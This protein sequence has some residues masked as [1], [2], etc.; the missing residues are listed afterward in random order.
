MLNN[1]L[2]I[3]VVIALLVMLFC[4]KMSQQRKVVV[5]EPSRE[6][7]EAELDTTK[8]GCLDKYTI[9][10]DRYLASNQGKDTSNCHCVQQ[11]CSCDKCVGDM[12]QWAV[13][14]EPGA[15]NTTQ[16]LSWQYRSPRM[17]LVDNS[18]RLDDYRA[19]GDNTAKQYNGP[20]G[21][22]TDGGRYAGDRSNRFMGSVLGIAGSESMNKDRCSADISQSTM[23]KPMGTGLPSMANYEPT[24]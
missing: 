19:T 13:K 20:V 11:T 8:K 5:I 3:T 4:Y 9:Q 17:T 14:Y 18:I 16:D 6:M 10:G 2:C 22:D 24:F 23:S 7:F 15:N 21:V 12:C 1:N